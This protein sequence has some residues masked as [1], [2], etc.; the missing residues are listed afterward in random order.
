MHTRQLWIAL[1]LIVLLAACNPFAGEQDASQPGNDAGA[2]TSN[3]SGTLPASS[4]NPSAVGA[5]GISNVTVSDGVILLTPGQALPTVVLELSAGPAKGGDTDAT[6]APTIDPANVVMPAGL[7]LY[8][9][10]VVTEVSLEVDP[11]GAGTQY[12]IF[13]TA[14]DADQVSQF[15]TE[16]ATELGWPEIYLEPEYNDQGIRSLTWM[17]DDAFLIVQC[18]VPQDGLIKVQVSTTGSPF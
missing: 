17:R 7:P 3:S 6:P 18:W 16:K 1:I 4:N 9:G 13:T 2:E 11:T 12:V 10:A 15:Y 14:D 8:P 5:M